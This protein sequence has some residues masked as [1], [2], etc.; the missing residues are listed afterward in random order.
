MTII[1]VRYHKTKKPTAM[2]KDCDKLDNLFASRYTQKEA[3]LRTG[4][5]TREGIH[6]TEASIVT[7]AGLLHKIEL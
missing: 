7:Y 5:L 3:G 2:L 1:S 4:A 6:L